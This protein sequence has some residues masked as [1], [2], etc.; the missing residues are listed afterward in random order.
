MR[1]IK[2]CGLLFIGG[3]L[4]FM[5]SCLGGDDYNLEEW[6]M[7]NAQ[8]STFNLTCDSIPD[9]KHVKFTIDQINGLIYNKDSMKYGTNLEHKV[10]AD[11]TFDNPYGVSEVLFLLA[12]GDTVKSVTD[13][14]DF[15][16]P[17]MIK[18]TAL[19]G[20]SVK[21]YEAKINVHQINPDTLI[22]DKYANILP[23]KT[24][25]DMKVLPYNGFYYMYAVDNMAYQLYRSKAKDLVDWEKL[26]LSGFPSHAKLSQMTVFMKEFVVLS[27]D[28]VLYYS[29]DGCKWQPA[30]LD[31]SIK[32][33]LGYLPA[34]AVSGRKDVLCCIAEVDDTLQFVSI[35][36]QLN[37]IQGKPVPET[38]PVEGFGQF[39]YENMY[40]PRLVIASGRDSR[41]ML[42]DKAYATMDGLSWASLSYPHQT[43]SSREGAAVFY[44]GSMFFVI[45]GVSE[46]G[47]ALKDV[48]FSK[49][50]GITWLQRYKVYPAEDE[51]DDENEV[52]YYDDND[53][54]FYYRPY[55]VMDDEYEARGFS[56]VIVDKDNFIWLFGGKAKNNTNVINEV[57]RGRINRLVFGK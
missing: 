37:I 12:S 16:A 18:V 4:S 3:L 27:D 23:E 17:V 10:Y 41:Y 34:S 6:M 40:Y 5:S 20:M 45:G 15:S 42:S 44:Y 57:W 11:V 38:F 55:Y 1:K 48:N 7:Y 39:D 47:D 31:F 14:I 43:F 25:Q 56:S 36:K 26:D 54:K 28:G 53:K 21:M 29:D 33:L 30:E 9:L 49:D 46:I 50:Q 32:T 2:I 52:Y 24:F 13:T 35:D 19:D 8:I 22:W 51:E